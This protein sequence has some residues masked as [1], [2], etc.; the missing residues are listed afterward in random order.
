[1]IVMSLL[2]NI[3]LNFCEVENSVV[4]FTFYYL[5]IVCVYVYGHEHVIIDRIERSGNQDSL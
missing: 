3:N 1:M 4:T 2:R 5:F